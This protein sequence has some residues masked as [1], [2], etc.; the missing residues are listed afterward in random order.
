VVLLNILQG[1]LLDVLTVGLSPSYEN[2]IVTLD[3]TPPDKFT[4]DYVIACLMNEEARQVH[5]RDTEQNGEDALLTRAQYRWRVPLENITC[6]KCGEKGHY[7]SHCP[8]DSQPASANIM[9]KEAPGYTVD[10]FAF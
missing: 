3:S 7:Q 9:T 8:K 5:G 2:F 1:H 4:L 10:D 6:F